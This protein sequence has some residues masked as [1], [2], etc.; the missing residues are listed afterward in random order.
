V[1]ESAKKMEGCFEEKVT[2]LCKQYGFV[3]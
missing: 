2:K 1:V 3:E